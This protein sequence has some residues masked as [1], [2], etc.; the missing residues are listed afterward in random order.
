[1][2]LVDLGLPLGPLGIDSHRLVPPSLRPLRIDSHRLVPLSLGALRALRRLTL[3]PLTLG[4][5]RVHCHWLILA[6]IR[7]RVH[8]LW[9]IAPLLLLVTLLLVVP[10][11]TLSVSSPLVLLL[12]ARGVLNPL[13]SISLHRDRRETPASAKVE[14]G[15]GVEGRLS[16]G[17]IDV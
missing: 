6:L 16:I 8:S 5:L 13:I 2:V 1:V 7:L 4:N 15:S 14:C 9:L 17:S 10:L 12:T 3:G 11:L